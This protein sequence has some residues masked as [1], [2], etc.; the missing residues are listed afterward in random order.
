VVVEKLTKFSHFYAI[1]T[2]YSAVQVVEL[3]FKE[4]FRLHGL[5]RNIVSDMDSRFI[6]TFWRDFFKLVGTYLTP[7]TSDH[8]QTYGKTEI[9]NK[10]VDGYLRNYVSR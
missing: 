7:N 2:D 1:P 9:V 6:G 3:F 10:W 5:P 4:V 8:P